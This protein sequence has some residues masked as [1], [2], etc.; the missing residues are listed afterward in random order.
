MQEIPKP[1]S[2]PSFRWILT[3]L[4]LPL[5]AHVLTSQSA[6]SG[7]L[8]APGQ[9]VDVTCASDST[10][11]YALYLPSTYTPVKRWPIVYFFDPGGRGARPLEL[12]KDI[13][14]TYGFIFAGSNNSQNFGSTNPPA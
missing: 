7:H 6:Q 12:Y 9:L 1:L 13:A 4:F 3:A 8:P 14:E 10:Q 2:A 11:S 5:A